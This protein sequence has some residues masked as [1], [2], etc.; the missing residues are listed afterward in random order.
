[1]SN[2]KKKLNDIVKKQQR[3]QR[4]SNEAAEKARQSKEKEK[5][6]KNRPSDQKV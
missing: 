2:I 5:T 3:L 1:M 6:V 4:I